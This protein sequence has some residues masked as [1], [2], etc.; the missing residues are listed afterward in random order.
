MA[1]ESGSEA[2]T[3]MGPLDDAR[4]VCHHERG[5]FVDA[6]NCVGSEQVDTIL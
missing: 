2:N 6:D 4:D 1:Q 3:L 5:A